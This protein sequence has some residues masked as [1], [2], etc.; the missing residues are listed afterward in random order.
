LGHGDGLGLVHYNVICGRTAGGGGGGGGCELDGRYGYKKIWR[1]AVALAAA[2]E[3][4]QDQR[5]RVW[6]P[7]AAGG[8]PKA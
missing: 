8:L 3:E 6:R 1:A 2:A 5:G 7:A 4:D